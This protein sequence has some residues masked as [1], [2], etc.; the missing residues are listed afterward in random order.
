[1]CETEGI[2]IIPL[3]H[4]GDNERLAIQ[5]PIPE[6]TP[7]GS[8]T[9]AVLIQKGVFDQIKKEEDKEKAE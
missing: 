6:P 7:A 9:L 2:N 8:K 4:F 1:M 3:D 5:S